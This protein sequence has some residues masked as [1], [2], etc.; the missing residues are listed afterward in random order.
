MKSSNKNIWKFKEAPFAKS[1][2]RF[3]LLVLVAGGIFSVLLF[4]DWWFK[5]DTSTISGYISFLA[6][7]YGMALYVW[8]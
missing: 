4:A 6:R 2:D 8:Y 7:H 5:E 3:V 1:L